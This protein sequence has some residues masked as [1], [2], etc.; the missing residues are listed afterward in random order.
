MDKDRLRKDDIY[1]QLNR[2]K[3]TEMFEIYRLSLKL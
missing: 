3:C 2:Y 1:P